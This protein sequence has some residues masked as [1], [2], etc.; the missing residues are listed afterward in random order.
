MRWKILLTLFIILGI[1]GLLI[2]TQKGRDFKEKYLDKYIQKVGSFFSGITGKFIKRPEVNRTLQLTVETDPNLSRGLDFQLEGLSFKGELIYDSVSVGG[3][4]IN[5]K[6][7]NEIV[8]RTDAMSGSVSIDDNGKMRISGQAPSIEL[9]NMVFTPKSAEEKVEFYLVGSPVTFSLDNVEKD[10]LM[11]SGIS[12][13][14][15]LKEWS[16]LE[17]DHDEL[18][19]RFF[20]GNIEQGKNSTVISGRAEKVT[21]NGVDLSLRV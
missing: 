6:D 4:N 11:F 15:R 10:R 14:L 7:D 3:Q 20:K 17:L 21:L 5:I 18:D 13:S 16:P 19:I 8:F 12:G 2:F 9:N 1:T